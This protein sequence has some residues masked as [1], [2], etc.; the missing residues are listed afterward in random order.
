MGVCS[1]GKA[2]NVLARYV[3]VDGAR[4]YLAVFWNVKKAD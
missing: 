4:S 3:L 1:I 2:G